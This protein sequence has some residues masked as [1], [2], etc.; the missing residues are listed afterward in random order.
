[1]AL[2]PSKTALKPFTTNVFDNLYSKL[3]S[4]QKQA[5]EAI[6]GAVMIIAGPGTG[7]TT[8]LALRIANILLKTDTKPENILALTFTDAGV[9]SMKRKLQ[10]IIGASSARIPVHTFHSFAVH[11]IQNHEDDF[12]HIAGFSPAI[13]EDQIKIIEEILTQ[14]EKENN[15][16]NKKFAILTPFGDP[17]KNV[18]SIKSAISE[19]KKEKISIEDFS[20]I[21]VQDEKNFWDI[22][23][24]YGTSKQ[25]LKK[26]EKRLKEKYSKILKK[27]EKNKELLVVYE[28]YQ[29][30]LNDKKLYDFDDMLLFLIEAIEKS[31]KEDG[32]LLYDLQETY[33]YVL[34]DEHQDANGAQNTILELLT[35]FHENPNLFI[36]GDEKQAIYRFQGASLE[37]FLYF[38][39]KY[40]DAKVITLDENYRSTQDILDAAHSLVPTGHLKAKNSFENSSKNKKSNLSVFSVELSNQAYELEYVANKINELISNGVLAHEIAIIYR[41]NKHAEP[42]TRVLSTHDIPFTITSR[43]NLLDD[44]LIGRL[45]SVMNL[46]AE[47]ND[48]R[49]L[50]EGLLSG[51]F[52]SDDVSIMDIMLTIRKSYERRKS[53]TVEVYEKWPSLKILIEELVQSSIELP[54]HAWFAHLTTKLSIPQKVMKS[55]GGIQEIEKITSFN[56]YLNTFQSKNPK[57]RLREFLEHISFMKRHELSI[58]KVSN[59]GKHK[60]QLMTAHGSKGLEFEYVFVVGIQEGVWSNIRERNAFMLPKPQAVIKNSKSNLK[61]KS[62]SEVNKDEDED[63]D[64]SSEKNDDE[65]RLLYVA[66]TRAKKE[67]W[68]L[69]SQRSHEGKGI[70]KSQFLND[71]NSDSIHTVDTSDFEKEL[72]EKPQL[73]LIKSESKANIVD[74]EFIQEIFLSQPLSVT[75]LNNYIKCPSEY[76]WNNL[77]RIPIEPNKHMRYGTAAHEALERLLIDIQK[78]DVSNLLNK[79]GNIERD[80]VIKLV[81]LYFVEALNTLPLTK[82]DFEEVKEKGLATLPGFGLHLLEFLQSKS[83]AELNQINEIYKSNEQKTIQT[84]YPIGNINFGFTFDEK[85]LNINLSGKLDAVIHHIKNTD[86]VS[87]IDYKTRGGMSRNEIEGKTQ[88][89]EGKYKRQLVFYRYLLDKQSKYKMTDASLLFTEPNEKGIYRGESFEISNDEINLLEEEIQNFA[90]DIMSGKFL[91]RDCDDKDCIHCRRKNIL[92]K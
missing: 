17:L 1:M 54:A 35:S 25:N 40:S 23:D 44:I 51:F 75:A 27:I 5:V 53:L 85:Q 52:V 80:E 66:M 41:N 10:E 6:E 39:K 57:A 33:Q 88:S 29:K 34:A 78:K 65:K 16:G 11:I 28:R 48:E 56:D 45:L 68:L 76:F 4:L 64:Q 8:I 61:S 92:M 71:L 58:K 73:L 69:S 15:N 67:L 55:Y 18:H 42:I 86:S 62:K 20:K 46:I 12:G 70:I 30:K 60:V 26:G 31:K 79:K 43:S 2:K 38:S 32:T 90:I 77:I 63:D 9:V 83:G 84:E 3:N 82:K 19:L 13:D 21:I 22:E 72:A 37:N 24:L 81:S 87:V 36:V 74:L 14:S 49:I 47:P 89:S 59:V 91:E 50:I 7:K